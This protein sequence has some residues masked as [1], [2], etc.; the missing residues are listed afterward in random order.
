MLFYN[1]NVLWTFRLYPTPVCCVVR[2]SECFLFRCSHLLNIR[3]TLEKPYLLYAEIKLHTDSQRD[4]DIIARHCRH[5]KSVQNLFLISI[6]ALLKISN[7]KGQ[8]AF[9]TASVRTICL[10]PLNTNLPVGFRCSIAGFGRES[11]SKY[12]NLVILTVQSHQFQLHLHLMLCCLQI[13]GT[14]IGWNR[15]MWGC[16]PPPAA[17]VMKPIDI[18]LLTTWS[19][20][21]APTGVQTPAK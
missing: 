15:L 2:W 20:L 8:G 7:N 21:Q 10:P 17:N 14:P 3:K 1:L 19:A 4:I 12:T 16:S 11:L 6:T 5:I 18:Y 13:Q 9:K